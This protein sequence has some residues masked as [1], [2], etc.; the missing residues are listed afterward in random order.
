M[1]VKVIASQR[2]DVFETRRRWLS[3]YDKSLTCFIN[4][5]NGCNNTIIAYRLIFWNNQ[6][7]NFE[8]VQFRNSFFPLLNLTSRRVDSLSASSQVVGVSACRPVDPLPLK[9]PLKNEDWTVACILQ[10]V[11]CQRVNVTNDISHYC[12]L[13]A[14]YERPIQSALRSIP[15]PQLPAA[16]SAPAPLH[17]LKPAHRFAL[18]YSILALLKPWLHVQLLHAIYVPNHGFSSDFRSASAHMLCSADSDNE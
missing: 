6:I 16:R 17:S 12:Q 3:D 13:S 15:A 18:T 14:D 10:S 2:W 4:C 9:R 5:L 1:C 11:Y 8:I 7:S